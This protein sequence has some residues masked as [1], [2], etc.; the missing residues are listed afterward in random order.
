VPGGYS[1]KKLSE[2]EDSAV[3]FGVGEVQEARF[4]NDELEVERTGLA[5]HRLKPGKRQAFAHKHE[6]AEEVYVVLA[7]SGRLKLD[8]DIVEVEQLDAI[9]VAP[10]VVRM[11]EAGSDGL[12]VLAFGSRHKGDGEV[13]RDW[14]ID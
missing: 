6:N 13:I 14:W 11:F 9:R 5:Y 4:P 2:V 3:K 8:D 1:R 10:E 12:D 7:G